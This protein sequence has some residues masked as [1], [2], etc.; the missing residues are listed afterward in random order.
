MPKQVP[1]EE[2]PLP[3]APDQQRTCQQLEVL[4]ASEPVGLVSEPVGTFRIFLHSNH[5]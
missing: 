2:R 1:R 3:G 5:W 4:E